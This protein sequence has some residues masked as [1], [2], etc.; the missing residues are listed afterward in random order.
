MESLR[1]NEHE[2]ITYESPMVGFSITQPQKPQGLQL[3]SCNG[4]VAEVA[5]NPKSFC[6]NPEQDE[7]FS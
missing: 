6:Q 2:M 4:G 3:C 1:D 7:P 5:T